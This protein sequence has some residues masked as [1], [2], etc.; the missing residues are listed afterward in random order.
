[1]GT[2]LN[3]NANEVKPS[4]P[5]DPIPVGWHKMAIVASERKKTADGKGSYLVLEHVVL[6]GEYKGKKAWARLNLENVNEKTVAIAQAQLSAICHAA[7]VLKI[8]NSGQLH[9]IPMLVKLSIKQ[10]EGFDPQNEFKG[11]K[12]LT[13]EV[14]AG[15]PAANAAAAA[16]APTTAPA[17]ANAPAW[18][19]KAS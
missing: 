12:P 14:P 11:W 3:F 5:N 1:M 16:A 17:A 8:T 13:G 6:D 4:A 15:I 19:K 18:A 7:G 9:N 10:S 2:D